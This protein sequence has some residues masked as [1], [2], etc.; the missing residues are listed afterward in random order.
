MNLEGNSVCVLPQGAGKSKII[1]EVAHRLKENILIL[2]PSRE[3]LSQDLEELLEYVD[4]S[5]V[6]VYSASLDEKIVK[7]YTF[8]TIQSIYKCPEKFSHFKLVIIDE[9]HFLRPS[10]LGG[11]FTSFLKAIGHPK[12]I[13]FTASPYRLDT[14]YIPEANGMVRTVTTTKIITRMKGMFWKRILYNITVEELLKQKYLCPLEYIDRSIVQHENLK[15]NKSESDFDLEEYEKDISEQQDKILEAIEYGESVSKSVLVFCSSVKQAEE[16]SQQVKGSAC[17]S[18]ST[19]KKERKGIIDGFRS[20]EIKTVMNV[21]ILTTGF[22]FPS[23]SFIILLR[24]TRSIALYYQMLG[25]GMRIFPGK[26]FCR[27]LDLTGTVKSLGRVETV[28]LIKR[29]KFELESEKG[30]WHNEPLYSYVFKRKEKPV[31]TV[32]SVLTELFLE[33]NY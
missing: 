11:M 28:K 15:L 26:D 7:F 27:V 32:D 13:G 31:H 24:P 6:G 29:E 33:K 14:K 1:A 17:V 2:T 12:V 3:I 19:P 23:L 5:E 21:G 16:L 9:C 4:R 30:S 8:A 20:G 10:N 18:A 22:N 25:R